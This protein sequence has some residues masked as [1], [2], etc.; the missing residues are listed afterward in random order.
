MSDYLLQLKI[1]NGRIATLM[2]EHG[3]ESQAELARLA[4]LTPSIVGDILNFK[5]PPMN[6]DGLWSHP[7]EAIA[8]VFGC[9][10]DE[11]FSP[12][13]MTLE[14]ESN[15]RDYLITHDEAMALAK[16]REAPISLEQ[17][18]D[19]AQVVK[20]IDSTIDGLKPNEQKVLAMRFGLRG[21]EERTL[22]E[23]GEE[24]GIGAERVR[25]IEARA[26]VR[27]RRR[28]GKQLW[29]ETREGQSPI[30][31]LLRAEVSG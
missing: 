6:K 9:L 12:E 27:I 24:L 2:R 16:G 25:Q 28:F 29:T 19:D 13:Q 18:C 26:L 11:M 30:E 23:I 31:H 3:I 17:M 5:K 8:N 10:P 15:R 22:A 14:V 20:L 7:V 21:Q 4:G 1:K